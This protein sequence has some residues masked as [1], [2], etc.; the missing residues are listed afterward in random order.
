MSKSLKITCITVG[1]IMIGIG[2]TLL[3]INPM[4]VGTLPEGFVT[5]IVALQFIQ[6]TND[7]SNFFDIITVESIKRDLILGNQIDFAYMASYALFAMLCC[8][9]MYHENRVKSLWLSIPIIA[10]I[11]VADVFENLYLFEILTI[12]TYSNADLLL[13]QLHLFTWLKWGGLSA[14]MLL[15]S[16]HF[17][18]GSWAK[19][20][21]GI[22][23][24]SSFIIGG[25]A[26]Y[27]GGIWCELLAINIMIG[28]TGLFIFSITWK[29]DSYRASDNSIT[30]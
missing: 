23:L 2:I 24:L 12:N 22:I 4:V 9:L 6:N 18:Q 28:F 15:F 10:L 19:V 8:G 14:L 11:L 25:V 27:L 30:E 20:I 1:V 26:F 3:F 16:V 29:P 5:P 7:L 13:K 17:L 21:L